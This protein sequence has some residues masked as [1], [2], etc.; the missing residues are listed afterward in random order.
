MHR[1]TFISNKILLPDANLTINDLK[2]AARTSVNP[3]LFAMTRRIQRYAGNILGSDSYMAIRKKE[4]L[5][6][7][8][9]E[10]IPTIWF[11]LSLANAY[12]LDLQRLFGPPLALQENE[13]DEAFKLRQHQHYLSNYVNN[14]HV[15]DEVFCKRVQTFVEHFF[16]SEGLDTSWYW[17]RY[18]WQRRGNIHTHGVAKLKSDPNLV[19][20]SKLVIKGRKAQQLLQSNKKFRNQQHQTTTYDDYQFKEHPHDSYM[21]VLAKRID[22]FYQENSLSDEQQLELFRDLQTADNAELCL[23]TYRDYML[24]STHP[25][26]PLDAQEIQREDADRRPP[27]IGEHICSTC[28]LSGDSYEINSLNYEHLLNW[29]QRHRHNKGYCLRCGACRFNFPRPLLQETLIGVAEVDYKKGELKGTYRRTTVT[30]HF[31]SNDRW[32]NSHPIIGLLA[33]GANM[34]MSIL[35]DERAIL[36][37]VTKYCTKN[38]KI[39]NGLNS[40]LQSAI[41][42]RTMAD[43]DVDT[44]KILRTFFNLFAKRDKRFVVT[45]SYK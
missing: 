7:M 2:E 18:E 26:P 19:Q 44:K 15:V 8:Q 29:C 23:C 38:E 45:T 14:P 10:G 36:E 28:H 35:I 13:T 34:D 12:W 3:T 37:Y 6:L 25:N 33:W 9:Y 24:S 31:R 41:R 39:S 32:L 17:Y 4:L 30:I 43:G 5:G 22:D 16:G 27:F 21:V 20:L 11:T 40:I 1:L 42:K